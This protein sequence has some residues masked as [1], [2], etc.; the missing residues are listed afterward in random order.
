MNKKLYRSL[1]DRMLG[2]VA[3]G[4][5]EYFDID[6]TIVRVLF[7]IT[8]F[9]G[10]TGILAYIILWIIVPEAPVQFPNNAQTGDPTESKAES[11]PANKENNFNAKNYYD[12]LDRQRDKRRNTG[13][14]ILVALGII[15][16]ADNF[17]PRIHFGD[18]WP[19]ILIAAGAAILLNSRRKNNFG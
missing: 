10:G 18:F 4:L 3:A 15:F 6:P 16:L 9:L 2:G 17:I 14:I 11:E 19:L 7:V 8:L 12:N 13:G 5:A 1:K